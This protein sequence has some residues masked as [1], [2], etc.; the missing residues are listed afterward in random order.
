VLTSVLRVLPHSVDSRVLRASFGAAK[1]R[2]AEPPT[3][4]RP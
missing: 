1:D 2:L 3:A 4:N